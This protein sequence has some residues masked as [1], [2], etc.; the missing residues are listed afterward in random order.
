MTVCRTADGFKDRKYRKHRV[1]WQRSQEPAGPCS[2]T[3]VRDLRGVA[4]A[5]ALS[6]AQAATANTTA[7]RRSIKLTFAMGLFNSRAPGSEADCLAAVPYHARDG[8]PADEN[9]GT[10]LTS[11]SR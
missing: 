10:S 2:T 4:A 7:M 6:A 3:P 1:D 11:A 5:G 9:R 8:A